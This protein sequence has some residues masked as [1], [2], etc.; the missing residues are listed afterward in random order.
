MLICAAILLSRDVSVA[1]SVVASVF[2]LFLGGVPSLFVGISCP[3]GG[4]GVI[5]G[6]SCA[7][8]PGFDALASFGATSCGS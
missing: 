8:A 3:S 1:V 5:G 4:L 2:R 7:V 6:S